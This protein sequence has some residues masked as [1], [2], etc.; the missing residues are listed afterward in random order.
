VREK[1]LAIEL[2]RRG[3]QHTNTAPGRGTFS[4]SATLIA[5]VTRELQE[6]A[7]PLNGLFSYLDVKPFTIA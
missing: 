3:L 1:A 5:N 7:A 2:W 4:E 6:E